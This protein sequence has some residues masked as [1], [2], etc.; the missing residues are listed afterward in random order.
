MVLERS[1]RRLWW[2]HAVCY[3]VYVRS[4]AD[5]DGDGIGDLPGITVAAALPARPRRRRAVDHAVLHLAAAATTA[6]TSPT[7]ATS[8]RCSARSRTPT[9][10][11]RA[12]TSSGLRVIVDIVPNHTSD[13][14]PWFRAAL[15]AGPGQPRARAL[16][17]PRRRTR[18][19]PT[20]PP[21]NWK[22]VFGGPAWTQV[23]DDGQW[24]LHLFDATQPDLDWRNPEVGDLFEDVLRF[25]LD[26][27]VD[28]FRI[29]VAHGLYKEPRPARPGPAP[30]EQAEPRTGEGSMV[31]RRPGA[32]SRCGTSPR[33]TRSTAAG[34]ESSPSTTATGWPW[35]RPGPRPRSRWRATCAP[36][37]CSQAFNFSWLL[38]EWSA[39]AFAEVITGTL[40]AVDAGRRLPDLGAQQPRRRPARRPAT[41][42]ASAGWPAPGRPRWRCWR[43]PGSA[44][45]YQGEELGLEQV[46]V[47]PEHRQDPSWFRTGEAGRDGCRVPIPWGGSRAA[48]RVR[49]GQRTA[50]DPAARRLGGAHRRGPAGRPGVDAGVLPRG[51][52]R[53]PS[54]TPT[55]P[56]R[57]STSLE[58]GADV[59]AFEPRPAAGACSTA[60][61][62]RCRCPR[63]RC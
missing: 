62:S 35:P 60:A 45:L 33:C 34:T 54:R 12:P 14:H 16:P 18:P 44:Y 52:G 10:C 17:L 19:T 40:D 32:T 30:K 25:W 59:L 51:A 48:V 6:T 57:R 15:A 53:A 8:T 38:A 29:D 23:A 56:A 11:W 39:T 63:A 3:Q 31:E 46:D 28:G 41:A 58:A 21:N 5:S 4:F 26:R 9:P 37:S 47:A 7:T 61:R 50:V 49:P 1:K 13:E 43:C 27:G 36:T 24:Y 42:A 20:T 2:R 55:R 22:S